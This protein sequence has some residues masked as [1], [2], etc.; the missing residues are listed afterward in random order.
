[1]A[2][3]WLLIEYSPAALT[4]CNFLVTLSDGGVY[5]PVSRWTFVFGDIAVTWMVAV[6]VTFVQGDFP[7]FVRP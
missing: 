4:S 3:G 7:E 2:N 5:A 6:T 1:M